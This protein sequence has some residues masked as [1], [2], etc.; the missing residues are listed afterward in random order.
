MNIHP[1]NG[2][3]AIRDPDLDKDLNPSLC[4]G[5]SFCTVQCNHRFGVQIRVGILMVLFTHNVKKVKCAADKDGDFKG[6]SK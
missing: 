3:V 4:N 2:T 5:N 6:K 1:K